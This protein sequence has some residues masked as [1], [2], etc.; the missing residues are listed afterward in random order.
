M[1]TEDKIKHFYKYYKKEHDEI[2][3]NFLNNAPLR[4]VDPRYVVDIAFCKG[5]LT[6]LRQISDEI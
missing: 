2:N 4:Y 5:A 3:N 1:K 6:A